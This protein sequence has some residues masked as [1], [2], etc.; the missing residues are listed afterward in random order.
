M[1]QNNK[2]DEGFASLMDNYILAL[3]D[4][5][6]DMAKMLKLLKGKKLTANDKQMLAKFQKD[7]DKVD[8]KLKKLGK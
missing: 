2:M 5:S 8:K 3:E 4:N 6:E 7:L 1:Q